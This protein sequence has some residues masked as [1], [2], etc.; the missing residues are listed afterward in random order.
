M[1]TTLRA[2]ARTSS[3]KGDR[4]K[5]REQGK[6]PGV[7]YGKGITDTPISIDQ[8]ELLA[9]LKSN[10]HAIIEMEVPQFGKQPVMIHEVQRCTLS[11]QLLH[12]DFHQINM[13][14]PVNTTVRLE[15]VGEPAGVKM[16]GIL[17][18][19]HHE[20]DIRCL[21]QQ[22]PASI[23]VDISALD[24]GEN[25]H[26][27]ELKLPSGIEVRNDPHDMVATILVPQKAEEPVEEAPEASE[28]AAEKVEQ[29]V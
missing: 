24:I 14:E 19:Q 29:P 22:I 26:I 8:K 20:I 18:L 17:Q 6:V 21:P 27:S 25:L 28:T 1:A 10:P 11:R 4:K 3:S 7:V 9:Q 13:N 5:L 23:E 2:E 16:G 12:V 15:F